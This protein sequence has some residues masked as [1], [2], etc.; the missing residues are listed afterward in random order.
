MTN[1]HPLNLEMWAIPN[2]PQMKRYI[3]GLTNKS[4]KAADG[5][6]FPSARVWVKSK[7]ISPVVLYCYLKARFGVPLGFSMMLRHPST[8]NLIQWH[9]TIAAGPHMI[10]VMARNDR[11]EFWVRADV[12]ISDR[13]WI[14]FESRLQQE[15]ERYRE[16]INTVKSLLE[17]WVL[18]VNPYRRL[19]MMVEILRRRITSTEL[20]APPSHITEAESTH[21]MILALSRARETFVEQMFKSQVDCLSL[22]MIAPVMAESFVNMLIFLLAR[23]E[24]KQDKRLYDNAIRS[25]IDVR[26]KSLSITCDGF[27]VPIDGGRKEFKDFCRM[28]DKRNDLYAF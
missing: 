18:F 22:R 3:E 6:R 9:F 4:K 14:E 28:M 23:P 1:D 16:P 13:D 11:I 25:Q 8:E 27:S 15:F 24:I 26:V 10:D 2:G 21:E 19:N 7:A 20:V 5:V 17:H 12:A